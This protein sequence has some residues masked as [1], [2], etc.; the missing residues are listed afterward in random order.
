MPQLLSLHREKDMNTWCD[1]IGC[2][3][4]GVFDSVQ[5]RLLNAEGRKN[6]A[7]TRRTFLFL[8]PDHFKLAAGTSK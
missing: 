5:K 8:C 4:V 7:E 2:S 3:E 6:I 1:W